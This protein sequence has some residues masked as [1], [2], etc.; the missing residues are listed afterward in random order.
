MTAYTQKASG[1]NIALYDT[2]NPPQQLP[3]GAGAPQLIRQSED[4]VLVP[5]TGFGTAGNF[6]RLC[7][8]PSDAILKNVELFVDRQ[9]V[10]GGTSSTALVLGVGVVFSDSTTDGTPVA[11][12]N[13]MPTTVGI[14]GGTT[15]VGTAVAIGGSSFNQVFGTITA[16][17]STGSFGTVYGASTG[18]GTLFGGSV[19]FGGT[20]A[21]YGNA[22][23]LS[24]TAL[25]NLFNFRDGS[26]NLIPKMGM[27]DL[28]VICTTAYNTQP[29]GSFNMY[30]KV[31]YTV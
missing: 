28:I 6:V 13:L 22:L 15:T 29:A 25:I 30:G 21:T 26:G 11:Y 27:L 3:A 19:M 18:S 9:L 31:S 10:D 24:Q 8:F 5:Q 1:T 12:Q 4:S 20:V 17:T 23:T 2:A 7:R 14:G 16:V